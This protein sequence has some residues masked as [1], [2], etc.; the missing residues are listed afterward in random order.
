MFGMVQ[1]RPPLEAGKL[2]RL[3]RSARRTLRA[4]KLV[5]FGGLDEEGVWRVESRKNKKTSAS[6]ALR[7]FWESIFSLGCGKLRGPLGAGRSLVGHW[8]LAGLGPGRG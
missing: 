7:G 6:T 5:S 1:P 2:L 8:T 4:G 3:P